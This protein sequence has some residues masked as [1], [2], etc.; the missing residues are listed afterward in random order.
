MQA[1]G[2]ADEDTR[3]SFSRGGW[4]T[5]RNDRAMGEAVGE[6]MG[7]PGGGLLLGRRSYEDMLAAWND[8]GG[9][10]V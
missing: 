8:R 7:T 9:P 6:R 1:P 5:T 2:R 3:G 4:A 10:Y